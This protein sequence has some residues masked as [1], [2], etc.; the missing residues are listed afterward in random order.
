MG[1]N[2]T[3]PALKRDPLYLSKRTLIDGIDKSASYQQSDI[4]ALDIIDDGRE[5]A[6]ICGASP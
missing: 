3:R 2:R 5:G 6:R 4:R 1:Q